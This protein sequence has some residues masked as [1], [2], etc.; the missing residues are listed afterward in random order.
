MNF[1]RLGIVRFLYLSVGGSILVRIG[2]GLYARDGWGLSRLGESTL[3]KILAKCALYSKMVDG[4][5]WHIGP[6]GCIYRVG[7]D[8]IK[9]SDPSYL[10]RRKYC[11]TPDRA[12]ES[13]LDFFIRDKPPDDL[14]SERVY[15]FELGEFHRY[16]NASSI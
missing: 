7:E 3:A 8:I 5:L 12:R 4:L 10:G 2:G 9:F 14:C 11:A 1:C 15:E 13:G 6:L 16:P